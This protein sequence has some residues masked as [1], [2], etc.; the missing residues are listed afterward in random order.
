MILVGHDFGGVCVSYVMEMFPSK[1]SKTIYIAAAMLTSG[2][3]TL[4]TYQQQV[5]FLNSSFQFHAV[6]QL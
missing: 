4:A 1:V 6:T 2:K 5:C 3:S